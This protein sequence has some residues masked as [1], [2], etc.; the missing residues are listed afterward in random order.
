MLAVQDVEAGVP[1]VVGGVVDDGG[2]AEAVGDVGLGDLGLEMGA[3][4]AGIG[5]L[6]K[7]RHNRQK[8]GAGGLVCP[9]DWSRPM[10]WRFV[11][12]AAIPQWPPRLR[13]PRP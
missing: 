8:M 12:L 13:S 10:S 3:L 6:G 1:G 9:W 2:V 4:G 5:V 7:V 11:P